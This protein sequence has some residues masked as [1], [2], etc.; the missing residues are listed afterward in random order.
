[1]SN[2]LFLEIGGSAGVWRAGAFRAP[3]G[4]RLAAVLPNGM[5]D[6]LAIAKFLVLIVR[7]YWGSLT[8]RA[9]QQNHWGSSSAT[10]VR[11]S[12]Q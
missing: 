6:L 12:H 4:H 8:S 3:I 7:K 2:R 9:Y 10:Y 11:L 1:M 5:R